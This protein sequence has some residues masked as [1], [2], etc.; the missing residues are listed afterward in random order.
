MADFVVKQ[1]DTSPPFRATLQDGL[2]AAVDLQGATVRFVM[3]RRGSRL[4]KVAAAG[5]IEQ[6][7]NGSDGSKGKI[8]YDW[9]T[10]NTDTPGLYDAEAEVT[11]SGGKIETFPNLSHWIV[12]ITDDLD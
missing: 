1:G 3:R 8:R 10:A 12:Y 9:L 5:V 7:G 11:F 4:T 6:V 2:G